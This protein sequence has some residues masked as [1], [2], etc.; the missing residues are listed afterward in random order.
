MFDI[1]SVLPHRYP[2]LMIDRVLENEPGKWARGY[3]NV[4][5]NEWFITES[6]AYMPGMMIIEALAQL[7]AFTKIDGANGLGFLSSLKE[8]EFLGYARPGDRVDLYYEV[9]R[10]KKG[11]IFGA[12]HASVDGD[13]IVK[14]NIGIYVD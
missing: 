4:T 13:I 8:V 11:F 7:G 10:N 9:I 3:K 1:P 12:C 2:F 5:W 14:A 6:Q